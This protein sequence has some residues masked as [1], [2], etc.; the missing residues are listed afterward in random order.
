MYVSVIIRALL[1]T[2]SFYSMYG[3]TLMSRTT[4]GYL[5]GII[6]TA[7]WSSTGVFIRFL[8]SEYDIPA[9]LLAF[10]RDALSALALACTFFIIRPALLRIER[11]HLIFLVLYGFILSLFNSL[12][13][14][15]VTFNGAAIS[16]VMVYSS[17]AYTAIIGWRIFGETLNPVKISAIGLSIIGT[18]FVAGVLSASTWQFNTLGIIT[19]FLSGLGLA[20]YSLFGKAAS[21]RDINPWTTT[22]YAFAFASIFIFIYHLISA[23]Q[24]G[25]GNLVSI[26]IP[27]LPPFGWCMLLLLAFIPTIGGYGLYVVSLT[28][29]QASVA[30][31]IATL[32]PVM[33]AIQSYFLLTERFTLEQVSGS[34]L[35]I[36]S[37]IIL[38]LTSKD[39][40]EVV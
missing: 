34:A 10:W 18:V 11:R 12:W 38:R 35:I 17:A 6:G 22:F 13:T 3:Y 1:F 23:W 14:Y 24:P 25:S 5:I 37:V 8:T 21:Q 16:T 4:K 28:Y 40:E 2:L 30:N 15:S 20:G 33:T 9:L 19:G 29:L 26:I 31:L 7:I 27:Q 32:E 39:E 36:A